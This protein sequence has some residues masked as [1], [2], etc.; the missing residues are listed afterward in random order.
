MR[1]KLNVTMIAYNHER[2]IAPDTKSV[3]TQSVRLDYE[4]I[5]ANVAIR[6]EAANFQGMRLRMRRK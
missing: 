3:L 6:N 5:G 2:F 4:T 1:T